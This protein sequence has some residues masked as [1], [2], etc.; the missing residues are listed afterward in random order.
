MKETQEHD[1][2]LGPQPQATNQAD[3]TACRPGFYFAAWEGFLTFSAGRW[4]P[5]NIVKDFSI[6]RCGASDVGAG[7]V[8]ARRRSKLRA[9]SGLFAVAAHAV[10]SW[11]EVS[12]D[13]MEQESS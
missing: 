13:S 4:F 10:T 3:S 12:K 6:S 2:A 11:G 8:L 1:R 5:Q 9:Y 7:L